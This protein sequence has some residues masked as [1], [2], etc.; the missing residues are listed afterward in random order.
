MRCPLAYCTEGV[1]DAGLQ[2]GLGWEGA[3]GVTLLQ[4]QKVLWVTRGGRLQRDCFAPQN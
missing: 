3:A 1:P 2:A 4:S